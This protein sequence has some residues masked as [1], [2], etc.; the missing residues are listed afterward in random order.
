MSTGCGEDA[1]NRTSALLSLIY[2]VNRD[3]KKER[4]R[5]PAYFNPYSQGGKK[6]DCRVVENMG[7]IKHLFVPE[8]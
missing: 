8:K 4:A 1:W 7:E 6:S 2:N 3:S 5:G